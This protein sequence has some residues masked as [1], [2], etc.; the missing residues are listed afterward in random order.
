MFDFLINTLICIDAG[1]F[2]LAYTDRILVIRQRIIDRWLN[3]NL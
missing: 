3:A 2:L 1:L